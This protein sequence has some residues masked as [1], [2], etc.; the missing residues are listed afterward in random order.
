M[1]SANGVRAPN[2]GMITWLRNLFDKPP[3]PLKGVP[4]VRREK[5]YSADTGY[6]YQYFYQGYR[7]ARRGEDVGHEHL[8]RVSSGRTSRFDLRIFLSR[9]ALEPWEKTNNRE[10]IPTEQYALVKLSLFRAFDE[11]QDFGEDSEVIVTSEQ[12]EDHVNALDL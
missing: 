2:A 7:E 10:L 6:V 8:F 4:K 9:R 1:G 11:R 3:A 5:T 12:V